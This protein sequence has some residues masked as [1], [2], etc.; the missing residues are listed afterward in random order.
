MVEEITLF[1]T[2][3]AKN[4][5]DKARLVAQLGQNLVKEQKMPVKQAGDFAAH[6]LQHALKDKGGGKFTA[7]YLLNKETGRFKHVAAYTPLGPRTIREM[8]EILKAPRVMSDDDIEAVGLLETQE[9]P[10][11]KKIIDKIFGKR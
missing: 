2:G 6:E 11:Y 5:A 10:W 8:I 1:E 9:A 3:E 4:K 7:G